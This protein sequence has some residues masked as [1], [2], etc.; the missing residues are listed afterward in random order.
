MKGVQAP[1]PSCAAPVRFRISSSLV[2]VCEFCHSVVARA[3]RKLSDRGKVAAIVETSSPL[4]LGLKGKFNGKSFEVVGRTQYT[5]AAGGRWDEWYAAFSN[6]KWGWLAEAQGRFYLTIE[7]EIRDEEHLPAIDQLNVGEEVEA[8]GQNWTVAETGVA[9]IAGAAGEIP[10]VLEPHGSHRY[11][12]LYGPG[13]RFAT[14][15]YSDAAPRAYLGREVTLDDL[16]IAPTVVAP[17]GDEARVQGLALACP[18]CGGPLQLHAPDQTQRVA[19]PNCQALLDCTEGK[20][21]YLQTLQ[22]PEGGPLIP[23]G[24]VGTWQ[25]TDYTVIGY[26]KRSTTEEGVEY[27]WFEYLLYHPRLGFRWLVQSGSHWS[28]V[29]PVP[30]GDVTVGTRD[31]TYAGR[32]YKL[33]QRGTATVRSVLG[34]FYWKVAVGEEV[35]TADFVAPPLMLS[36]ERTTDLPATE[37]GNAQRGIQAKEIQYS[38]ATYARPEEIEKAFDVKGLG[39]GWSIAPNQPNPVDWRI[40][41]YWIGFLALIIGVDLLLESLFSI[42]GDR[43]FYWMS[44]ILVSVLPV[45]GLIYSGMFESSRWSTSNLDEG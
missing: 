22:K 40:A 39:R 29:E 15:D 36:L 6:G 21:E 10:F 18:Q 11:A 9:T 16:G 32:R 19:C 3:D 44:L 37:E 42:R 8:L 5:H 14:F 24:T 1:C 33:F 17:A 20:L 43:F 4:H 34:E 27:P 38:L 26:L 30:P 12:D 28:F 7:R 35:F 23:L 45:A 31:R 25:G 2:A 41:L 13:R